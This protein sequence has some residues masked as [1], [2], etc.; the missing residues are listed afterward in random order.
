MKYYIIPVYGC[1]EPE[2]LIGPF[3]TYEKMFKRAV[4]VR[5]NQNERDAIFWLRFQQGR[6]PQV[7]AFTNAELEST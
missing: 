3:K 2:H 1:V 4:K 7:S 5:A 6:M